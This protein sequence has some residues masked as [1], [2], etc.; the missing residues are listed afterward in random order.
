MS[1]ASAKTNLTIIGAGINSCTAAQQ[2]GVGIT[3]SYNQTSSTA[4]NTDLLINRTETAV[5]SGAQLLFDAQVGGV[6]KFRVTNKGHINTNGTAPALTSC[7][8]SPTIVTGSNDNSG[9]FTMG[10][11]GTGCVV[12]FSTAYTNTPSCQVTA[13]TLANMVS[14]TKT[15][16]AIT[17]VGSPGTYDYE[18]DFIYVGNAGRLVL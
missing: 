17:L 18:N 16:A 3:P 1:G 5:G 13:Q 8:T 12:T 9:T 6:S 10:A 15:N 2:I 4:A 11:T 14:Y 7:G